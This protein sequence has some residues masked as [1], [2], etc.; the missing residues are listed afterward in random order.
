MLAGHATGQMLRMANSL[1]MTRLLVP[2]M[3]GVMAIASVV[4]MVLQFM[5]DLGV[6]HT[7]VQ[8]RRGEDPDFLDTAYVLQILRGTVVWSGALVLS[9]A[10]ALGAKQGLFPPDS[11]YAAPVL[12]WII[13][14]GSFGAFIY[15]FQTTGLALAHRHM[16]QKRLTQ[17]ELASQFVGFCFMVVIGLATRSIWALVA[18][19]LITN[20]TSVIL[21]HIWL[22]R[23][24]R[25]RWEKAASQELISFGKWAF[26]SS[27]FTVLS[28]NGDRLLLGGYL[29]A[30]LLG[31]YAIAV[32]ILGALE[33]LVG[34]LFGAV[35]LPA[36]S[37]VARNDPPRLREVY[38]K[39]RVPADLGLL[40]IGGGLIAGGQLAIDWLYDER[41]ASA[42]IMLQILGFATL[43]T[44]YSISY[45]IYIAAARPKY[46]TIVNFARCL[47]LFGVVPAAFALGG[48]Y[49]AIW[50][51]ALHGLA[52]VPFVWFLL[53]RLGLL[54]IKRELL[55]LPAL[56]IGFAFGYL[57]RLILE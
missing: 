19:A 21:G 50:G 4:L 41:Y 39:L 15:G 37:E 34:G 36:L 43:A 31:T 46:L 24:D 57:V 9:A 55:V 13:A 33:G 53:G 44:R 27:I 12:P 16:E 30:E 10:L 38:Y 14:V 5:S 54:D 26:L 18:G 49:A 6:H 25:F 22:G 20:T 1:I 28:M 3:F 52:M 35:A 47:G 11:V 56:P 32:L 51:I 29:S 23:K 17:L 40:F 45:Q 8:S 42:G 7:I 2:E 48:T